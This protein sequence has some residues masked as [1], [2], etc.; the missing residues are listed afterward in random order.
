MRLPLKPP[1]TKIM[2]S[3]RTVA[4]LLLALNISVTSCH[5]PP[6]CGLNLSPESKYFFSFSCKRKVN[7]KAFK[8]KPASKTSIITEIM[9]KL[10]RHFNEVSQKLTES[11]NKNGS[12]MD[13]PVLRR[14]YPLNPPSA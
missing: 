7:V 8:L 5:S 12:K 6:R 10:T 14:L 3:S 1:I 13:R 2:S 4:K 9:L 11:N